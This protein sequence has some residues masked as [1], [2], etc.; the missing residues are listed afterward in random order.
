M[1]LHP[2]ASLQYNAYQLL[3]GRFNADTASCD[4]LLCECK[5]QRSNI[6]LLCA[7]LF[8]LTGLIS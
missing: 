3:S 2:P 8:H 1:P 4:L 6:L 5:L 7:V